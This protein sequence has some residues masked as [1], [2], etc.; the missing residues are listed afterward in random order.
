MATRVSGRLPR[1]L[2]SIDTSPA[3]SSLDRWLDRLP[4]LSRHTVSRKPNSTSSAPLSTVRTANRD[5]SVTSRSTARTAS[6]A[7]C[8]YCLLLPHSPP[9]PLVSPAPPTAPASP[10]ARHHPG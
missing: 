1:K 2:L 9:A 7:P 4:L 3:A 6:I 8:A 10:G 5:G